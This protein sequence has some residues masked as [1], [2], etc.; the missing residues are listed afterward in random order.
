MESFSIIIPLY[1]KEDKIYNTINSVLCQ[2]YSNFEIIVIDDGSTDRSATIVKS[3]NDQRLFYYY[4]ENSGVSNARNYGFTK[5]KNKWII[6][7]DADD[8]LEK[9]ALNIFK[10]IIITMPNYYVYTANYNKFY[11]GIKHVA[12]KEKRNRIFDNPFMAEWFELAL[13]RPGS[14]VFHRN[15]LINNGGFNSSICYFEDHDFIRKVS[16]IYSIVYT[17]HIVMNYFQEDNGLNA[18]RNDIKKEWA[19]YYYPY[20]HS[21][22][23]LELLSYG[24]LIDSYKRRLQQGDYEGANFYNHILRKKFKKVFILRFTYYSLLR[25]ISN[26]IHRYI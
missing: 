26:F 11:R 19:Y 13:P 23:Y 8:T 18:K 7:L 9:D 2:T 16:S 14:I 5:S 21:N 3:I 12:C 15:V 10:D 22:K 24:F 20:N 4:I 25:K 17:P 1:N 6:F